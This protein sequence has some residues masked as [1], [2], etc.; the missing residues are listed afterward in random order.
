MWPK[1]GAELIAL[2]IPLSLSALNP[3]IPCPAFV[4][5][6]IVTANLK[7]AITAMILFQLVAVKRR[8]NRVSHSAYRTKAAAHD[9][10]AP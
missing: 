8:E 6:F 9:S 10:L 4:V 5:N 7:I 1:S 3:F 2:K